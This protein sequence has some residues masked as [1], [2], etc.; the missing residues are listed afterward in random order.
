[1]GKML[2]V[3]TEAWLPVGWLGTFFLGEDL[4]VS[5]GLTSGKASIPLRWVDG[6]GGHHSVNYQ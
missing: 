2:L 6:L 5:H 4:E 1:M 3:T